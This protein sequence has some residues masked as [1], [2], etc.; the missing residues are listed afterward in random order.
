MSASGVVCVVVYIYERRK[1]PGDG[2]FI[3]LPVI[4]FFQPAKNAFRAHYWKGELYGQ[5]EQSASSFW[6]ENSWKLWSDALTEQDGEQARELANATLSRLSLLQQTANVIEL[7]PSRVPYQH[8]SLY[9]YMSLRS[10]PG[11]CGPT[12]RP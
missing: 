8:G 9:S 1:V 12:N 10:F 4:L 11:F 6:V 2:R 7:T 3:V 5:S